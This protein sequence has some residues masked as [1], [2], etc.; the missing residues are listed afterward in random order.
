MENQPAPLTRQQQKALHVGFDLIAKA[1][2]DAGLDM[3]QVLKP[4]VNI[5]WTKLSVKEYI[6][7]PILR[8]MYS[9]DHTADMAKIEE[10]SEVWE[11]VMRFLMENHGIQYIPF[12]SEALGYADTAPMHK[13]R[14]TQP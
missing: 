4:T 14:K 5:P 8:L 13:D 2:N 7:K 3:R 9:K 6:Y 1:L 11:T 12:P 10:P